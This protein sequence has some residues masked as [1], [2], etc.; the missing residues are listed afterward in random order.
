MK[1]WSAYLVTVPLGL[2]VL[3]YLMARWNFPTNIAEIWSDDNQA[4][5]MQSDVGT[6]PNER[7]VLD[8]VLEGLRQKHDLR[9]L[10][11]LEDGTKPHDLPNGIYG[12][13]KC[14]VPTLSAKRDN[15]FSLEIHKKRDGIVY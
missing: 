1:R 5:D 10:T 9:P 14:D 2:L 8:D 6:T 13:S 7:A 4:K 3:V 15:T 11:E 12:F